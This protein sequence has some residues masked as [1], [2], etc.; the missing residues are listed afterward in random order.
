M[1]GPNKS[2]Y[3]AFRTVVGLTQAGAASQTGRSIVSLLLCS[4]VP[5]VPLVGRI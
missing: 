5:L 3:E 4:G 2:H 1:E